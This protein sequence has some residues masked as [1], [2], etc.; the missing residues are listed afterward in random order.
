M[1]AKIFKYWDRVRSS[2]WFLPA[3]M[4]G[5]AMVLAF[6]GVALDE[7]VPQWLKLN[8]GWTFTGGAEG[9]SSLLGAIA[10]SMITIAGVVFSM[11]LVALSL[12]SSQLGPRLLRNLMRDT[13]TQMALGTFVATFL[14]CLL[15]LRTIRR[16]DEVAFVPHLSV[17][18]AVLLAVVSVGVL[19]YFIH[20]VS[21]S[22]Q[23]NEIVARVG[24]ELIEGIDHLFPEHI[25]RGAPRTPT[26]PPDAGFLDTFGRE[27]RPVG[28]TADGYLQFIDGDALM[29]LA[30]QEDAVFRLERRP[31]HYVVADRPLVF[32]WPGNRVTDQL[33]EDVNSAFSM[34]NQRT[35]GQD[36]EF[37]VDQ[38]VEIAIR[39]LSPGVNDPFTAI[40]C[41]D[42][43]GS[44]LCR[45]A[46]KEMPSPYRHDTKDQLRIL[47]PVVT[48]SD[49]TDAA[50]NQI[51][52]YGRSSAAVTIRLLETIAVIAGSVHRPEDCAALLRQ[53]KMIARG[54]RDGLLEDEDR[55]E[56]ERRYQSAEQLLQQ[57]Q[58]QL[59]LFSPP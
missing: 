28:S 22:I 14:Y 52:Q 15:V 53:A 19:I 54:A 5:A 46:Q 37:A 34:G 57:R 42:R 1:R 55:Q 45:L 58:D 43:L 32:V 20:H 25:G 18:G 11:T 59:F 6:A 51:R 36:F 2:F 38:L 4:A 47:T 49:V 56:V 30:T 7:W 41:V 29:A 44:A 17:T 48:F 3:V 10:G 26:G 16:V 13:T 12:A 23:V 8:W 50:F 33:V 40:T 31:G 24:T 9:A 35:S 21:V 39:A 27:A